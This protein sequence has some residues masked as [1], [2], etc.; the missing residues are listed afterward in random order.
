[1][2]NLIYSDANNLA[3]SFKSEHLLIYWPRNP[4]LE[5]Y[6]RETL[7]HVHSVNT[8]TD[9]NVTSTIVPNNKKEPTQMFMIRR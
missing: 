6:C 7:R 2:C 3:V 9:K 5:I 1:M 4:L 8:H